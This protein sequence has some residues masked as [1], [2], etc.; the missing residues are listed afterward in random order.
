MDFARRIYV[1]EV[2]EI[3]TIL[4]NGNPAAA[5]ALTDYQTSSNNALSKIGS[6]EKDL[7]TSAEKRDKLKHI[8]RTSTGL[9]EVTEEG[10]TDA[11]TNGSN[12]QVDIYKKEVETLQGK[13]L[14]SANAVDG[15]SATYEKQIFGLQLDRVVTMLGASNDVHNS[16]AYAV[17][18]EELSQ[19]AQF[20]G[21]DVV[22][23]NADGTT[24]YA[25]GGSPASVKSRYDEIRA[26]ERFEYLFKEQFVK[27][28][29]KAPTGPT[30]TTGGETIRRSKL[31]DDGKVKY[32]AKNGMAA[33]K[34]LPY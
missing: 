21:D 4:E 15:V 18:L 32:I 34:G 26:D 19:N 30:T 29:G 6:L 14:D 2:T 23:K 31:D 27:G 8:I 3:I 9:E 20:D 11:L 7:K 33:Y 10:L 5:Q 22:Y 13:L 17:V 16:H 25:A 12:E 24:I 1:M 28:G